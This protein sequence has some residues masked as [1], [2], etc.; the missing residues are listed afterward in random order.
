MMAMNV[1]SGAAQSL[2]AMS[3]YVDV[4]LLAKMTVSCV[5]KMSA[6]IIGLASEYSSC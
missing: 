5:S 2:L 3:T 1:C 6:F 4:V